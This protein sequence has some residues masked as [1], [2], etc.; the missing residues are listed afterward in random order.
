VLVLTAWN[1]SEPHKW[2]SYMAAPVPDRVLL[3]LTFVLTV[4]VDLTVAIGAGVAAGFLL[5]LGA[6]RGGPEHLPP[7]D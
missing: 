3:V 5:R 1:M 2:R 7:G 4:A 6:R